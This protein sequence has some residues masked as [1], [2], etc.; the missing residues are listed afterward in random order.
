MSK[1]K[2][3]H[4][5]KYVVVYPRVYTAVTCYYRYPRRRVF[6]TAIIT[7]VIPFPP[8]Q[9]GLISYIIIIHT[10]AGSYSG[11]GKFP[12]AL[13]YAVITAAAAVVVGFFPV[14]FALPIGL[15]APAI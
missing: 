7:H 4:T 3:T 6:V 12:T 1:G 5:H 10:I 13:R 14:T 15:N 8:S 9:L 11:T 2:H